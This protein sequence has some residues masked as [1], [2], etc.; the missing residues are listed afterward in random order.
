MSRLLLFS[1]LIHYSFQKYNVTVQKIQRRKEDEKPNRIRRTPNTL[2]TSSTSR[3]DIRSGIELRNEVSRG[4]SEKVNQVYIMFIVIA[5]CLMNPLRIRV[6]IRFDLGFTVILFIFILFCAEGLSKRLA[7]TQ[8]S[9]SEIQDEHT[10]AKAVRSIRK[11]KHQE[12]K[13]RS[14]KKTKQ[15]SEDPP[16]DYATVSHGND[17]SNAE[18]GNLIVEGPESQPQQ[19]HQ[20]EQQQQYQ[21]P[22]EEE[23]PP[24]QQQPPQQ[25]Q[26]PYQQ[27]PPQQQI[28]DISSSSDDESEPTPIT[29]LIPK[30]E[31]DI[32]Y[33]PRDRLLTDVLMRMSQEEQLPPQEEDNNPA[34]F[35]EHPPRVE[36]QDEVAPSQSVIEVVPIYPTQEVIGISFNS[37]DEHEPPSIKVVVPKAEDCLVTSP[38]YKLITDVLMSMGQELPPESQPDSAHSFSLGEEF[39]RPLGTQEQPLK[40]PEEELSLTARTISAIESL[41][42]QVSGEAPQLETPNPLK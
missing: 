41:D 17:E 7:L 3:T 18:S 23:E 19:P 39:G 8:K 2:E 5:I 12:R 29:V 6:Y 28:I 20:Q 25:Q 13:E 34:Q 14:K 9:V 31:G 35:E 30:I 21:Q 22:L 11:R 37:E 15:P 42:K 1:I 10:F 16:I 36:R 24:H 26:P 38:S 4:K 27:Q 40:T 32:E 33:S